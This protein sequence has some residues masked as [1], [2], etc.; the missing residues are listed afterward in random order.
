MSTSRLKN[1]PLFMFVGVIFIGFIVALTDGNSFVS[2]IEERPFLALG[3]IIGVF[4][5]GIIGYVLSG[6]NTSK[7]HSQNLNR[8]GDA[9][10]SLVSSILRDSSGIKSRSTHEFSRKE[11]EVVG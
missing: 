8:Y 11:A 9:N 4:L 2:G 5:L 3:L 1:L 10:N 6:W 7:K